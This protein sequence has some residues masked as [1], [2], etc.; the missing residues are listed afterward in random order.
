MFKIL[1]GNEPYRIDKAV[2][3]CKKEIKEPGINVG[4]FDSLGKDVLALC[5]TYPFLEE[6]RLVVVSVD[7]LTDE[8]LNFMDIPEFTNLFV[9]PSACDKRTGLFKKL[10]N[11]GLTEELNKLTENQLRTFIVKYLKNNGGLITERAYEHLV[12]RSG[13]FENDNVNLYTIEI[14][15]KQLML[16]GTV[17]TDENVNRIIHPSCNENVYAL[18]KA[19]LSNDGEYTI[20]LCKRLLERGEQPI[21]LLSLLLRTFRLG[22]KA[23]LFTTESLNEVSALIGV[24][25][26]QLKGTLCYPKEILNNALDIIQEGIANVKS[27]GG[28]NSFL[29]TIAKLILILHPE[30]SKCCE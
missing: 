2:A 28:K 4:F 14:Y 8:V 3:K 26:Y 18:T 24:S 15:L 12:E 29:F 7:S 9:L 1:Y 5:R 22:Y 6:N 10:S 27:G 16:L 21:A 13:Y 17:I 19:L 11:A 25:A 23:S 20:D 30:K